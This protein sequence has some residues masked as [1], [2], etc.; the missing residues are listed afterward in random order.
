MLGANNLSDVVNKPAALATLGGQPVDTDLT[1][2]AGISATGFL[3]R[4]GSGTAAARTIT[5]GAG[6]SVTNGDGVSGNPTI[7][8][9]GVPA[10][11]VMH[12]AMNSPPT[13]WLKA[14]G[15][16][17]SRTTYADLFAAIG[18][19]FGA[20]DGSTTFALP[21]LRAE[22]VRGWDDARGVDSGRAFG[23]AQSSQN[24]AHNHGVTD[25]GHTHTFSGLSNATGAISAGSQWI[26]TPQATSSA[27]T[28]I[29]IQNSGGTEARP[30]N[31]AL[32][33]CIKF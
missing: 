17:V 30:R 15:A 3:A 19:T 1:A 32:L 9:A 26:F 24:L 4:T 8:A 31:I 27:T 16:L 33:A 22:F 28:G 6:I 12:F 18:T 20:G 29:S 23:S 21:D 11:A 13:G 25:P 5:A 10:G 2:L 14:N 7:S